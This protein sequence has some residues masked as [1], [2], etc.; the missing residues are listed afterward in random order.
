MSVA[1]VFNAQGLGIFDCTCSVFSKT[2]E[3][4]HASM[5]VV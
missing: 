1:K 5:D 4:R 3:A 2:Q